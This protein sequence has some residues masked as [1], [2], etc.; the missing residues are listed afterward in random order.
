M[1]EE[2]CRPI[3]LK[4]PLPPAKGA[5]KSDQSILPCC[6]TI[7]EHHIPTLLIIH[8]TF[9]LTNFGQVPVEQNNSLWTHISTHTWLLSI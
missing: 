2:T 7:Y 1:S 4:Q 9:I 6:R 3:L 8:F 5:K